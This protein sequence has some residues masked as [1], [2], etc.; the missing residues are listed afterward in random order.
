MYG[1]A[2]LEEFLAYLDEAEEIGWGSQ[3]RKSPL[4]HLIF[5]A[6]RLQLDRPCGSGSFFACGV[7][8]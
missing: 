5:R 4:R 2:K 6:G 1:K 8:L 7:G 3:V